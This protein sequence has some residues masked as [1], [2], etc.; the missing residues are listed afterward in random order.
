MTF[1][2]TPAAGRMEPEGSGLGAQLGKYAEA[3]ELMWFQYVIGYDKQEQ[4]SLATSFHDRAFE[5]QHLMA[6]WFYRLK[7]IFS[8]IWQRPLAVIAGAGLLVLGILWLLRIRR[9]G[10]RGLKISTRK[11]GSELC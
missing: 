10:W 5:F 3:L 7:N 1:D 2:P 6:D 11:E 4:R 9:I 8:P